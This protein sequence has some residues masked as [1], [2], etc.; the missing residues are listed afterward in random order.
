MALR[1][2]YGHGGLHGFSKNTTRRAIQPVGSIPLSGST[3]DLGFRGAASL[4]TDAK[5][6]SLWTDMGEVSQTADPSSGSQAKWNNI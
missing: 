2:T 1:S 6:W 5:L 4:Q 3:R